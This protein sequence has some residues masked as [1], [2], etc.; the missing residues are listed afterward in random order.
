M[1]HVCYITAVT[2]A[3]IQTIGKKGTKKVIINLGKFQ[4]DTNSTLLLL[5]MGSSKQGCFSGGQNSYAHHSGYFL[6]CKNN[7]LHEF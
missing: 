6:R 1:V 2:K 7:T 5:S 4:G 3:T